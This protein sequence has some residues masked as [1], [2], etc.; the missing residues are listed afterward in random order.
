MAPFFVAAI[1]FS[2]L[3]VAGDKK[4]TLDDL[5]PDQR[6][7][8]MA[9]VHEKADEILAEAQLT[10]KTRGSSVQSEVI[11]ILNEKLQQDVR[12]YISPDG[13]VRIV[14]SHHKVMA[15]RELMEREKIPASKIQ[16]EADIEKDFRG[17][18][19]SRYAEYREKHD[20]TYIPEAVRAKLDEAGIVQFY[21]DLP[22][23]FTELKNSPMRSAVGK[24]FDDL[25]I[26]GSQFEPFMQFRVGEKLSELGITVKAGEE[27]NP[28]V[29]SAIH[30]A[31]FQ[32]GAK[33][34]L[35]KFILS[36]ALPNQKAKVAEAMEH[37]SLLASAQILPDSSSGGGGGS[38][39][40]TC[41]EGFAKIASKD[42][43][44][45]KFTLPKDSELFMGFMAD[46]EKK[47]SSQVN[48]KELDRI[49]KKLANNEG[50]TKADKVFLK[51]ARKS[52]LTLRS[53]IKLFGSEE[54]LDHADPFRR[55][56]KNLGALNDDLEDWD[57]KGKVPKAIRKG[58]DNLRD[59]LK[60]GLISGKVVA[61]STEEFLEEQREYLAWIGDLLKKDSISVEQYHDLRKTVRDYRGM[62]ELFFK[63]NPS[64]ENKT[65]LDFLIRLS[66]RMGT[67]KDG[68]L[69]QEG[70]EKALL[71]SATRIDDDSKADLEK[72]LNMMKPYSY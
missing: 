6:E 46:A 10:A 69:A 12:A 53:A 55:M 37:G 7:V 71:Q 41:S 11:K 67:V 18:K 47:F 22:T 50:L 17:D 65:V 14:D 34:S 38:F 51:E 15:A 25:D 52:S 35:Y 56:V 30:K 57:F 24:A 4:F 59:L 33:S 36:S 49:L 45:P 13:K 32:E 72:F 19:W 68:L 63:V 58:A 64:V 39:G 23:D 16:F 48:L 43:R 26:K 62:L 29:Q 9:E 44:L 5:A 60:D 20:P 2:S 70:N 3:C 61:K 42:L 8:G 28:K 31:I 27:F 1:L 40:G 21:K 66:K 54:T